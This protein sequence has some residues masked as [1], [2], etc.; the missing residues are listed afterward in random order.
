M[1][2][3]HFIKELLAVIEG[4]RFREI[5]VIGVAECAI[6]DGKRMESQVRESH[7]LRINPADGAGSLKSKAGHVGERHGK[8]VRNPGVG[9]TLHLVYR[10]AKIVGTM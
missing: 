6:H 10:T 3:S 2:H 5:H 9:K 1:V 7:S 8:I 4:F